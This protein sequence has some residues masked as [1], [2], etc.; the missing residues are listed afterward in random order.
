MSD[1]QPEESAV[2][3]S[4]SS[5]W[6]A[7]LKSI[8][9]FNGDLSSITAPPFI[10]SP[11]SL[12]EYSQYWF[13]TRELF[14][15]AADEQDPEERFVKVVKWFIATLRL[16]Y[17]SRNEQSGTEKKPLNPALHE[18]FTAKVEDNGDGN[19]DVVLVSEQVSHHPPITAYSFWNDS[20]K[21]KVEGYNQIKA[22]FSTTQGISVK[23]YGHSLYQLEAFNETYMITL[24][25]LHIEGLFFGAPYVELEGKSYIQSNTGYKATIDY[26]GKGYF[27][28]KKN[29]FKAKIV[30]NSDPK[31]VLYSVHGQWSDLSKIKNEST[32]KEQVFLESKKITSAEWSVKP[33]EEQNEL[34]SRRFWKPVAEAIKKGD[35]DLI[36]REK[37]KIENDQRQ[38]RKE[39]QDNGKGNNNSM[40]FKQV[41]VAS[42]PEY[43]DLCKNAGVV[44]GPS[45]ASSSS[46]TSGADV[47]KDMNWR[48]VRDNFENGSIKPPQ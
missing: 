29:S 27:S 44:A 38:M 19:G 48:F 34:E 41:T 8:A 26:S 21:I 4:Q 25:N 24:P 32:G 33:V 46:T 31:K 10:L 28:G 9:S 14:F 47:E 13:S 7:F 16:Q 12:V 40:W 39:E 23:Q 35:Y 18:L 30:K 6:S 43:Q 1:Q 5:S 11:V 17:C 3:P 15:A 22:G 2:P 42:E 20:K 45:H 37:S 36:H